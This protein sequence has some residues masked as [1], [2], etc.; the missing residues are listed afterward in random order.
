[1]CSP[2]LSVIR[3]QS[4][5]IVFILPQ[6]VTKTRFRKIGIHKKTTALQWF[7]TIYWQYV[8]PLSKRANRLWTQG[9]L[10]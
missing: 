3:Y 6:Q 7:F 5:K 9:R 2:A 4:F 10:L 1:M 8:S